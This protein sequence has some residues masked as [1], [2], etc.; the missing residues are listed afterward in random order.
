[1]LILM[2]LVAMVFVL[3][4]LLVSYLK[5]DLL[6][7]LETLQSSFFFYQFYLR[8]IQCNVGYFR[9]HNAARPSSS[10]YF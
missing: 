9:L 6:M 4:R 3:L 7:Q 2:A 8:D 10:T 1:M 5:L